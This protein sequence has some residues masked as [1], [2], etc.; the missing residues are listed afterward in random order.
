M[1]LIQCFAHWTKWHDNAPPTKRSVFLW[2]EWLVPRYTIIKI[3]KNFVPAIFVI[4]LI[5]YSRIRHALTL[6]RIQPPHPTK[7]KTPPFGGIFISGGSG[8]IRTSSGLS[9]QIYSL[10]RLSNSG[11][12]PIWPKNKICFLVRAE[13][14]EP[15]FQAWK[16]CILAFV[17]C[18]QQIQSQ[19]II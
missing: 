17:L 14:I 3:F 18:P 7:I 13:G 16:A 1:Q 12:R 2:W 4:F 6:W 9:Q 10:P 15:S 11:A 19:R 8:W 5:V